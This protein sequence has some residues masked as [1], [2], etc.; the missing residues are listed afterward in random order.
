MAMHVAQARRRRGIGAIM[1]G[2][3]VA[4]L[5]ESGFATATLWVL[6]GNQRA[7]SCYAALGWAADGRT[8][9]HAAGGI[10]VAEVR[11]VIGLG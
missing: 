10:S 9:D 4:A 7:R 3:A 5:A 6:T 11:Y 8:R 1:H 2:N